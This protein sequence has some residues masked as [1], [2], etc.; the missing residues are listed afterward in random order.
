[1][2]NEPTG[3]EMFLTKLAFLFY[4]RSIYKAF[5]DRLPLAGSERVL[6]FGCG[7][8]SVAYYVAQRLPHGHLTCLDIS[9]RRLNA[10][11]KTLKGYGNVSFLCAD[12]SATTARAFD[13]V[14][15][16]FVLHD[17]PVG[18][19]ARVIPALVGSLRPGGTLI[20]GE[21]LNEAVK[22]S[23]I[24]HLAVQNG[25]LLK[26]SRITDVPLMGN[27]LESV[28]TKTTV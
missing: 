24:K 10:C 14:Y 17:I 20:F 18:E 23:T 2:V 22:L 16:H 12:A 26:D 4:G 7:S 13:V 6:N 28:Y 11:R 19:L 5:A 21:P 27:T 8:R 3:L 15:C 25:L 9:V 1:M